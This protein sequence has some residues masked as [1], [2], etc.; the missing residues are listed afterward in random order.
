MNEN[1]QFAGESLPSKVDI[2]FP[3]FRSKPLV[4][5][6]RIK[7][8]SLVYHLLSYPFPPF[9]L[10]IGLFLFPLFPPRARKRSKRAILDV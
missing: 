3:F 1:W 8:E 6:D 10:Y 7:T 4:K 2:N 5:R 9:F